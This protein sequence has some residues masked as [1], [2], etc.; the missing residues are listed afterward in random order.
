MQIQTAQIKDVPQIVTLVKVILEEMELP[1]LHE[2]SDEQLTKLFEKHFHHP[3]IKV[4]W[5]I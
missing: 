1:A 3:N 4:I 5:L 2:L